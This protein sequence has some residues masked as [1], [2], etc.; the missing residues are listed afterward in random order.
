MNLHISDNDQFTSHKSTNNPRSNDKLK[1]SL[2]QHLIDCSIKLIRPPLTGRNRCFQI[3][4][5]FSSPAIHIVQQILY[6]KNNYHATNATGGTIIPN[7]KPIDDCGKVI[8]SYE[9]IEKNLDYS[10]AMCIAEFKNQWLVL[11]K[12]YS[13][14][15][16][17]TSA[18]M[19][20]KMQTYKFMIHNWTWKKFS[21]RYGPNLNFVVSA[22]ATMRNTTLCLPEGI[23]V[24]Q[25]DHAASYNSTST[26]LKSRYA[27]INNII[28]STKLGNT[29]NLQFSRFD[30]RVSSNP[31]HLML[32]HLTRFLDETGSISKLIEI[33]NATI[34]PMISLSKIPFCEKGLGVTEMIKRLNHNVLL[35][36]NINHPKPNFIQS[37]GIRNEKYEDPKDISRS[38]KYPWTLIVRSYYHLRLV[39]D[40]KYCLDIGL[41]HPK[42]VEISDGSISKLNKSEIIPGYTPLNTLQNFLKTVETQRCITRRRDAMELKIPQGFPVHDGKKLQTPNKF[43]INKSVILSI[44]AFNNLLVSNPSVGRVKNDDFK[45]NIAYDRVIGANFSAGGAGHLERDGSEIGMGEGASDHGHEND[46]QTSMAD[47]QDRHQNTMSMVSGMSSHAINNRNRENH[48]E[49]NDTKRS[50]NRQ[51]QEDRQNKLYKYLMED[52]LASSKTEI[53]EYKAP[54]TDN[55]CA[56]DQFMEANYLYHFLQNLIDEFQESKSTIFRKIKRSSAIADDFI[57]SSNQIPTELAF[58]LS[59]LSIKCSIILNPKMTIIHGPIS[60]FMEWANSDRWFND[61]RRQVKIVDIHVDILESYFQLKMIVFPYYRTRQNAIKS[62]FEIL[63]Q[64]TLHVIEYIHMMALELSHNSYVY[65]SL[66]L[67]WLISLCMT[68]P[69]FKPFHNNAICSNFKAGYQA[70]RK[71]SDLEKNCA[72]ENCWSG[73]DLSVNPVQEALKRHAAARNEQNGSQNAPHGP[74]GPGIHPGSTFS[75][76]KL[77]FSSNT[78]N[79]S[80]EKMVAIIKFE[81]FENNNRNTDG[82]NGNEGPNSSYMTNDLNNQANKPKYLYVPVIYQNMHNIRLYWDEASAKNDPSQAYLF[83]VND[84][85]NDWCKKQAE[86]AEMD[87]FNFYQYDIDPSIMQF[88]DMAMCLGKKMVG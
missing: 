72:P 9:T 15:D 36:D 35:H 14:T 58:V 6:R 54:Q 53:E 75:D 17:L 13:L 87:A 59:N 27:K 39:Y 10:A 71:L 63:T 18:V 40:Q 48:T 28:T 26:R 12:F 43:A 20:D 34:C 61:D 29:V 8:F 49:S 62:F 32:Y 30:G 80:L 76:Q 64:P 21:I 4:L 33:L 56:L 86:L 38:N 60:I 24:Q 66:D 85:L 74:L 84:I 55:T 25:K 67:N 57:F 19:E 23:Q 45:T 70:F 82:E 41:Q 77:S 52:N 78:E 5:T 1:L 46:D 73:Y 69:V 42:M 81:R 22:M 51:T 11:S 44:T 2:E 3:E 37:T 65:K 47:S 88:Y 7:S 83:E 16:E 50:S 31:H 79:E 68:V